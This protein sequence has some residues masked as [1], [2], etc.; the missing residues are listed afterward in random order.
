MDITPPMSPSVSSIQL[1]RCSQSLVRQKAVVDAQ[2]GHILTVEP[3]IVKTTSTWFP[4]TMTNLD[5]P[6]DMLADPGIS[7]VDAVSA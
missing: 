4:Q 7:Y 3:D 1:I 5:D 6:S 2:S